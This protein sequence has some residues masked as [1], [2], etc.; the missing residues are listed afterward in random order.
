[1][2]SFCRATFDITNATYGI[3]HDEEGALP[4]GTP[5]MVMAVCAVSMSI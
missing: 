3:T 4:P 1:V 2:Y 5:T